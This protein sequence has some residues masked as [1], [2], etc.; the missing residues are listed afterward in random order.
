MEHGPATDWGKDNAA[1]VKSRLGVKMFILYAVVYTGFILINVLSPK[2]MAVDVGGLNLAIVY[3]FGL[4]AFALI[5][6]LIYNFYCTR[7]EKK[8]NVETK[9]EGDKS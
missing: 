8:M 5:L 9:V 3:G 4:I 7:Y 6:A 1:K 2:L